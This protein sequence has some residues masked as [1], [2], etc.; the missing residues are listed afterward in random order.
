MRDLKKFM[1]EI[2]G[3]SKDFFL[4]KSKFS[5]L[6]TSKFVMLHVHSAL[7]DGKMMKK[8]LNLH[9][10]NFSNFILVCTYF[11]AALHCRILHDEM[12]L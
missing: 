10:C 11:R 5:K 9:L 12:I 3:C 8:K 1:I 4:I 6:A 7:K 2:M